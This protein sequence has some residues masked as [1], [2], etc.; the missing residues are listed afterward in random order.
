MSFSCIYCWINLLKCSSSSH[1]LMDAIRYWIFKKLNTAGV[2]LILRQNSLTVTARSTSQSLK[3]VNQNQQQCTG[4]L[5]VYKNLWNVY[6]NGLSCCWCHSAVSR[7]KLW[8]H[9]RK[10]WRHCGRRLCRHI[11]NGCSLRTIDCKYDVTAHVDKTLTLCTHILHKGK[12]WKCQ[13][14]L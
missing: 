5:I 13:C 12:L 3:H 7:R 11:V 6:L 4:T 1:L 10:L 14:Q 2:K 8:C 9:C